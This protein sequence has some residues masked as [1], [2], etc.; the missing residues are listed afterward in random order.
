MITRHGPDKP[1][2]TSR[3][4][5]GFTDAAMRTFIRQEGRRR[6]ANRIQWNQGALD[7]MA[8]FIKGLR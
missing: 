5:M 2:G 4:I 7:A 3:A 1:F 6:D 8:R